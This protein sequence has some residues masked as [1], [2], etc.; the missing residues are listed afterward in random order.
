M[1][2]IEQAGIDGLAKR[3]R[4]TIYALPLAVARRGGHRETVFRTGRLMK[5]LAIDCAANLCAACVYDAAAGQELGRSVLDLGKGH[6]EHLMAVIDEALKAGGNRLCRPWR[7][8]RLRRSG[9]LH[10]PARRRLGGAR[11]GAGAENPGDRGDDAGSAGG[12][13]ERRHFPAAPVL[14]ALD[15]GRE[16]IHAALYDRNVGSALWSGGDHACASRGHGDGQVFRCLPAPRQRRSPHRPGAPSI[17]ARHGHRRHCHLRPAGR[18]QRRGR[19]AETALSARRRRQA[20]GGFHSIEARKVD[21]HTFPPTAPPGLC[22]RA[23][24]DRRQPGGLGAASRGFRPALDRWRIRRAARTGHGVRL[25][26]ARNRAGRQAA[27]RLRAGAAG[28]RRGRDPDRR[29]GAL[30]SPPGAR[31]AVDGRGA[32]RTARAA[33]RGAVPRGRRDQ[34]RGDRALPPAGLPRG[35]QARRITTGRPNM[36]RPA[37]LSCAAIFASAKF[38]GR[39]RRHDRK[40][41]DFPGAG[42]RRRRLAGPR[43]VADPVDED[44]LVAGNVHPQDL[45]QADRQGAGHAHPCQGRAVQTSARCWLPPT[46]SPGP[47]SWCSALWPM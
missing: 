37:R 19:K 21:A 17:S 6:A 25:C 33:R 12:R 45:A 36:A 27:G 10:R 14:A 31:L 44:R 9:L 43:A 16:E 15:A 26:R 23:A 29:G 4:L 2:R 20:A 3:S 39:A 8:C 7:H 5:L 24:D 13:G 11:P 35:R 41:Q 18:C 38:W 42:P 32:A 40:N 34:C 47:T 30:A 46:I 22:A 1:L 28:G